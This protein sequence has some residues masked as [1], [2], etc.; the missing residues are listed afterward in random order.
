MPSTDWISITKS[1]IITAFSINGSKNIKRIFMKK[2]IFYFILL[3]AVVIGLYIILKPKKQSLP[4]VVIIF[5]DDQGYDDLSIY[6]SETINT[7]HLD[8]LAKSG[9]RFTDFHVASSVCTPSRAALL[10][11]CYP[12]R[13]GLP[14]VLFPNG[15][16][17]SNPNVGLNP[18]EETIAEL[19]KK[20]GYATAMAGKWHLG[21]KQK[22]L[23]LQHGFDSYLGVPY[24]NDMSKGELPLVKDNKVVEVDIDQSLLTK[25]YTDFG[26]DFIKSKAGKVPF[27]LYLAHTMPHIP[28]AASSNYKGTSKGGLYGDVIEEIDGSVGMIIHELKNQR[29]LENTLVIFT[30]DNGPWLSYGN[31]GG[32]AGVLRGGKFDVWEG[33]FR[34]PA[35]MSWPG[36]IP[37]ESVNNNLI[38]TMDILPTL[39]AI[40]GALLPKNKI[41]GV[42][43]L[44]SLRGGK[45][46]E[47][48]KRIF[49]YFGGSKIK[50]VRKGEWKY[51]FGHNGGIVTE[52]GIDG[53]N[54]K[55]NRVYHEEALYNLISDISEQD[56]LIAQFSERAARLKKAG[57]IFELKIK[58]EA[59]PIGIDQ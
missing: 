4:N 9:M 12:D 44:S 20:K 38:H 10:T 23:P 36:V 43:V 41:D 7:P 3:F 59:R 51:V 55:T 35:I 8:A 1:E 39:I 22:F 26:I 14:N 57:E 29:L 30:S 46:N 18:D 17:R 47:L 13:V 53:I 33:G 5:T 58:A 11:G 54:G 2:R 56:N 52:P 31:H 27:F 50:A 21:H 37:S 32:S 42:N 48:Q 40:T 16:Y 28:L 6:G 25:R 45:M 15:P 24:S 49:Y 34:V 19:L